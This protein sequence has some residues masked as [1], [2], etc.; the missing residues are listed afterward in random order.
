MTVRLL[1]LPRSAKRLVVVAVDLIL[2]LFSVWF[3][4][5]LRIDRAG[6]PHAQ[7]GYVYLLAPLLAFPLFVRLGLYRAIFRYTGMAAL[8]STAKAVGLYGALFFLA[9][10]LLKLDGVPRSVGLIQPILFLLLVGASRAMARF[11]LAGSSVVKMGH[12]E[13]RLLIYGAGAAGVQTASA[14]GIGRQFVL[15]GFIDDDPAK[16]G[17]SINGVDIMGP[18][19]VRDAVE[20]MAVTDILLAM[21]SLGRARRNAIIDSL[22]EV[23]VHVRTLP[24]MVDLASGRVTVGDIQEL[25]VEDLLGRA[26]VPPDAALLARNLSG[27]TVLVTGAGGSIGSELCRQIILERPVRLVLVEH[28]EFGLYTI[29]RELD[30][31]CTE[32]H[33]PVEVVPLLA[34]VSNLGRL[35]EICR[36]HR[37]DTVYHAAAYKHVP[38]VECN[39][40]EGVLNNVFGTLNMARAAMEGGVE[41]FV[42][43]STDKAVRPTNVMGASKRL[44]EM[45]LQALAARDAASFGILDSAPADE[46]GALAGD[47]IANRTVFAMVRFGNVLGSS[48]SVVPLFRRQLIKGGP[49]TVTHEEVTRYFMTIPEAAQLVLQAGAMAHGGEVFVL[50]MGRP[51]KI[52]DLA[53]RMIQLAG[54]SVRDDRNPGGD[55]EL[56]ITGLRPGEKLYEELLI[57]DNPEATAHERIM[58]ARED[59]M[60]WSDLAPVLVEIRQAAEANDRENIVKVLCE[61]VH[62]YEP[63]RSEPCDTTL[64]PRDDMGRPIE[65]TAAR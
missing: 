38:L 31:L 54:L 41:Y 3:A 19:D 40:S 36:H 11:W 21:P 33:L 43:V 60:D 53:K 55:V 4:F 26:P 59:F 57:G 34:S 13:G 17:R 29:H 58:K 20:R 1:E 16:I 49:L 8:A 30:G 44:A 7:Q 45:V 18:D 42:L 14:L 10:M 56:K 63:Q 61:H 24:G 9:L 25:D 46:D 23:P 5:Y 47:S 50:D 64:V 15:L 48:G 39:P 37:P 51:V 2:A 65:T 62:G 28:N 27:K 32:H 12:A 22:R 52:V 6:L 35:R